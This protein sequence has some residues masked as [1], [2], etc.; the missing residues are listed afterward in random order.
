[1]IQ[2]DFQKVGLFV[3]WRMDQGYVL[4]G[5][6]QNIVNGEEEKSDYDLVFG[7]KGDEKD[8]MDLRQLKMYFG[9]K[10]VIGFVVGFVK[11]E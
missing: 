2:F 3:V 7:G 8:W 10:I 9:G 11:G 1:M 5:F 4:D 6:K